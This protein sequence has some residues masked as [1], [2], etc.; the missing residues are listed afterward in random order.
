VFVQSGTA[1]N[2]Q[3]ELIAADGSAGDNLGS[4]VALSGSTVLAGT[5]SR[6]VGSNVEQGAAYVFA[7]SG[8]IW[9]QQAE[10]TA[11][12]G[13]RYDRFGASVAVSGS[14]ALVGSFNHEIGSNPAQ[15]AA[16]V[17]GSSSGDPAV[18][19]SP[20]SLSFANEAVNFTSAAKTVTL[21]NTGNSTL[22]IGSIEIASGT[23]FKIFTNTCTI[24]L[25]VGNGCKVSVQFTPMSAGG[26]TASLEFA[27]NAS[28]SPQTVPLSGTGIADAT[29]A[30]A[31]ATYA[32][33]KVGTTS[34]AKTF[35]LT[36]NQPVTLTSIA[37]STSGNFAVSTKTCGTSLATKAKCTIGVTFTP[38]AKGSRTG[39]LIIHDSASS[40]P[41]T[42]HLSGIGK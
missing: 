18:M 9:S 12:D 5:S 28:D 35:T 24:T 7:S 10:L 31:S 19:L 37:I 42:S 17:F 23:N 13:T 20:A 39:Q 6:T 21:T 40:S 30:P 36:N 11:S 3:A 33:Q 26:L 14:T 22:D 29:L 2:Q 4:A 27:D 8:G 34:A 1:W 32:G 15:G 25:A 16:Y 41:Q 38:T